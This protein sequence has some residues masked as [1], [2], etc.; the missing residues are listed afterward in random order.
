MRSTEIAR[1]TPEYPNPAEAAEAAHLRDA[2]QITYLPVANLEPASF[3]KATVALTRWVTERFDDLDPKE[4]A[5][6]LVFGCTWQH[7]TH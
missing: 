4:L 7:D 1:N 5:L 3:D 6:F 2:E